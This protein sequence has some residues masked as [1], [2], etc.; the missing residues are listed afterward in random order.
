MTSKYIP[1]F[2]RKEIY[3]NTLLERLL[4]VK[5]I[6]HTIQIINITIYKNVIFKEAEYENSEVHD[7]FLNCMIPVFFVENTV[8]IGSRVHIK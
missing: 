2:L 4:C 1:A 5:S 3:S 6:C 8:D 7:D